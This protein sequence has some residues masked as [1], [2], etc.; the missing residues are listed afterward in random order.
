MPNIENRLHTVWTGSGSTPFIVDI[1][2]GSSVLDE[3]AEIARA[4]P[5][6]RLFNLAPTL[7]VWA[8]LRPLALNYGEATKDVY[9]HI[10]RFVGE[11]Y[12]DLAARDDLKTRFRR[13]ARDLGLPVSGN[14]PT[15]LFFA[16]LGPAHAQHGD[17]ARAFVG[18][19]LHHGPPA[20]EDTATARHWQR[21]AVIER[22][23]NLTRLRATALFDNSAHLAR[24]FEAW[25]QG[26]APIGDT[27]THLF[28]AYDHAAA[29]MGRNRSDLVGPPRLFWAGDRLGLEF[30]RSKRPQSLRLGAIPTRLAGG[31]RLRIEPPWA[32]ELT[33]SAGTVT[34]KISFAP[35]PD[36]ALVF[37][38]DSG[39]FLA[40]LTGEH[41]ELEVAAERLIVLS[42]QAFSSTSFGDAIPAKDPGF[43]VAWVNA[44]E[45]LSFSDRPDIALK[46]PHEDAIWIDGS[47]LG[48][49]GS[50]ALYACDGTLCLKA[51]PDIGGP[52]RIIRARI[53]DDVRFHSISLS[54]TGEVQVPFSEVRLD[55]TS[56]PCEVVFEVLTPGAAGDLGARAALS[57]RGWIWPGMASPEDDLADVP[58]PGN[59]SPARSSGLRVLDGLL[60]VDPHSDEETPILGLKGPDRVHEFRLAA[61]GEKLW[62]YRVASGDK[63]F[64]PRGSTMHFGHENR[65]DTLL[66]RSPDRDAF[67]LV[68]GRE[69]RRPFFQ[70]QIIEIG[71]AQ[72]EDVEDGDDRIALR[73]A[74]GRV[75]LLARLHRTA[76][77]S[78]LA[79]SV[80]EGGLH[81][82]FT[83]ALACHGLRVRIEPIAGPTREGE[84]VFDYSPP[85]IPPLDGVQAVQDPSSR[86][87]DIRLRLAE[88]PAPARATFYLRGAD[89]SYSLLRDSRNATVA[90]GLPGE[91]IHPDHRQ[92]ITLARFLSRLEPESLGGQLSEALAP[93]Y[94]AAIDHIG[95]SRMLGSVKGVLN[96]VR[97]GGQPAR[98]D[99]VAAAP[100]IFEAQP[101]A[102]RGLSAEAGLEPLA[103]MVSTVSPDPAPSLD[104]DTPLSD[105]LTRIGADSNIPPEFQADKLQHG[106]RVLRYRL[107]ETDLHDLV[108]GGA[109]SSTVRLICGARV[110]GLEQLRSFDD[111]GGGDPLPARIAAQVERHARS[112]A[113]KR[114]SEL[115]DAIVFRTGLP[116]HEVGQALTLM[117]RAGVEIFAYFRALWGHATRNGPSPS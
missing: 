103:R 25:R 12:G 74:D 3:A 43:Y 13:A 21:R 35:A 92:L 60:S 14:D 42:P 54:S 62:H 48:R 73:R 61:R 69:T 78:G 56:D 37:D 84:H 39:A 26:I 107:R 109:L 98:H 93:L 94:E 1:Q 20:I 101:L 44:A 8:A 91:L 11:D 95:A 76:D 108:G 51:D 71:A 4:L 64:V 85:E 82:S 99:L 41:E 111:N 113:D 34:Q 81:L 38:A 86:R 77:P 16:P 90:L 115:V 97:P 116:R 58:V 72:L 53:G 55:R 68:L 49:D 50:R 18:V 47:V 27:E 105:W 5:L 15:S 106:F 112:C 65:H 36:E 100:W 70:R 104:G 6:W 28:E 89:G 46:T 40:R 75:D 19:A 59:F 102:F 30:E 17:L 66:L 63:A 9:L 29:S 114:A 110:D 67:L 80:F 117:L 96:V 52:A 83:P 88:L 10:S 7:A 57:T 79:V 2:P 32:R 45:T 22:C 87:I 31:D 33:W 24:R 23:P